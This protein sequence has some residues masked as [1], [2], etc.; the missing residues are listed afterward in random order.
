M[1]RCCLFI[2][3]LAL[4]ACAAPSYRV[5]TRLPAEAV[6]NPV[7]I[8][9]ERPGPSR[10]RHVL[11]D[12]DGRE[13]PA[14]VLGDADVQ[15][16]KVALLAHYL[17]AARRADEPD[18]L[19]LTRLDLTLWY[20]TASGGGFSVG[21]YGS[22][23]FASVGGY[24]PQPILGDAVTLSLRGEYGGRMLEVNLREPLAQGVTR[25]TREPNRPEEVRPAFERAADALLAQYRQL[26]AEAAARE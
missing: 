5:A 19:R 2:F 3:C 22:H 12:A 11:H 6:A 4:A 8:E 1:S 26:Q 14:Q 20:P 24:T 23:G 16:S 15:P 9:D 7:R 13:L 10:E 18:T 17:G 21:T 25:N